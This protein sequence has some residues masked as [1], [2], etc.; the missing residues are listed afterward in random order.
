MGVAK[1]DGT[2]IQRMNW[3][4]GISNIVAHFAYIYLPLDGG[5]RMSSQRRNCQVNKN[6]AAIRL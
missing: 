3:Q 4:V 1:R 6:V 5:I 2:S